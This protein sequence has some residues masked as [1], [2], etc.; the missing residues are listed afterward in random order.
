MLASVVL[1]R[2][3]DA[4]RHLSDPNPPWDEVLRCS[5]QIV[6]GDSAS[7]ILLDGNSELLTLE[8]SNVSSAAMSEYVDHFHT[9]DIVTPAALGAAEG[10][11]LDTNECFPRPALQ[12]SSYYIDFMCKHRMREMLTLVVEE[13]PSRRGALSIQ[14][15]VPSEDARR[16]LESES[17]RRFATALQ[18][19]VHLRRTESQRWLD[20]TDSAFCSL[21]EATC[22]VTPAGAILRQTASSQELMQARASLSCRDGHLW[23]PHP[24]VRELLRSAFVCAAK[25]NGRANVSVPDS[26]GGVCQVDLVHADPRLGMGSEAL[27]FIRLRFN[28][29]AKALAPGTLRVTYGLTPAE[30]RLLTALVAGQP[31]AA[32]ALQ[33]GVSI[34]TVRKQISMLMEKMDCHRLVDLVRKGMS[35]L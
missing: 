19:A 25:L 29:S 8:Q 11:W 17:V 9:S 13:S 28:G 10:T 21:G 5:H 4:V 30:E 15:A 12:K 27:V 35:V 32:F 26:H 7:F 24:E 1:N 34:H 33:R 14:R 2:A 22:L 20:A 31:P 6:G 23:H 16:L 3:L 18:T